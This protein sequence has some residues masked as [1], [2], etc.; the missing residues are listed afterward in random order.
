MI[1]CKSVNFI[2]VTQ[3]CIVLPFHVNLKTWGFYNLAIVQD[4]K[5]RSQALKELQRQS[6]SATQRRKSEEAH[7]IGLQK[8]IESSQMDIGQLKHECEQAKSA[9]LDAISVG[10]FGLSSMSLKSCDKN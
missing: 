10:F 4:L 7:I 3:G 2:P 1:A 5:D 6:E 8:Q 9:Q